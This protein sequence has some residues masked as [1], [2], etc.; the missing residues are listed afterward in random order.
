MKRWW[1]QC[2]SVITGLVILATASGNGYEANERHQTKAA[3]P[4]PEEMVDIVGRG[5]QLDC[6]GAG[7]PTVVFEF[8]QP[9]TVIHAVLFVVDEILAGNQH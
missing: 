7:S 1:I 9:D 4:A 5:I 8:E 6:G 3:F 2:A